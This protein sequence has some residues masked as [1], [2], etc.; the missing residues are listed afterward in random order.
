MDF[1]FVPGRGVFAHPL[2]PAA[3]ARSIRQAWEAIA[4]G[5]PLARQA[6]DHPELAAAIAAF[7]PLPATGPAS[8]GEAS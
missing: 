7:G 1:G 8:A 4:H 3:G 5:I 2:G 6:L